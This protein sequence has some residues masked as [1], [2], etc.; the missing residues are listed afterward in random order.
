MILPWGEVSE[1]D[2]EVG[3]AKGSHRSSGSFRMGIAAPN[4]VITYRICA[5]IR[6]G[7]PIDSACNAV[8]VDAPTLKNW[9]TRGEE[10]YLECEREDPRCRFFEAFGMALESANQANETDRRKPTEPEHQPPLRP[11]A[12]LRRPQGDRSSN[13]PP[14]VWLV[15]EEAPIEIVIGSRPPW[16]YETP[17]ERP[18]TQA[19]EQPQPSEGNDAPI[20]H[21]P[22]EPAWIEPE[23]NR[24]DLSFRKDLAVIAVGLVFLGILAV[25]AL[26]I[27]STIPI[28]LVGAATIRLTCS[29]LSLAYR[30]R[31]GLIALRGGGHPGLALASS[32]SQLT[33]GRS[34]RFL[35]EISLDRTPGSV[36]WSD[37][38]RPQRE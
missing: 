19:P 36:A 10:A 18:P 3:H 24:R 15:V 13:S 6:A 21:T 4:R 37:R 23:A 7:Q 30:W 2:D 20:S 17:P 34:P 25:T 16:V 32:V 31:T 14:L 28:I 29:T 26:L 1:R 33:S 5:A 22:P 11:Q 12:E 9:L 27:L 8:G 38:L 35:G